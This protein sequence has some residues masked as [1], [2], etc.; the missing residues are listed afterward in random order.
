MISPGKGL[1]SLCILITV[2]HGGQSAQDSIRNRDGNHGREPLSRLLLMAQS[3]S[4]YSP[5]LAAQV[6]AP[7]CPQ[8]LGTLSAVII[9]ED[10]PRTCLQAKLMTAF[11][12]LGFHLPRCL[13]LVSSGQNT[14]K[15]KTKKQKQIPTNTVPALSTTGRYKCPKIASMQIYYSTRSKGEVVAADEK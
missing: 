14:N 12:Q 2:L 5:A 11:S 1:L 7:Q 8:W 3:V 10:V 6:Q 15:E 9:Q 4:S 13:Q